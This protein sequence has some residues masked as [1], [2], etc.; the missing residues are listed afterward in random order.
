M[1]TFDFN[2][3]GGLVPT[4]WRSYSKDNNS[5]GYRKPSFFRT[6]N[7]IVLSGL[8]KFN[9]GTWPLPSVIGKIP[10][11]YAPSHDKIF[12][13][14]CHNGLAR[15]IVKK[16]GIIKV[17]KANKWDLARYY[18]WL[19]LDGISWPIEKGSARYRTKFGIPKM[20]TKLRLANE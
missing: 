13:V 17:D 8:A 11:S 14:S 10:V 20:N 6:D 1:K 15:V 2:M 16:N 4:G 18:G 12:T 19:P 9:K 7:F 3:G 5:K